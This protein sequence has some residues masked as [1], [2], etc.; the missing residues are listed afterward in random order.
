MLISGW[1][2]T[3]ARLNADCSRCGA[4]P[5]EYCHTP[6]G[7]RTDGCV[8]HGERVKKVQEMAGDRGKG[9]WQGQPIQLGPEDTLH[10]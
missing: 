2:F 1:M 6:S 5:R 10:R 8:P 7:R 4:K 3:D 9:Y